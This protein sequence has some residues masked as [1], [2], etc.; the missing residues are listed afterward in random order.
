MQNE[1]NLHR[2]PLHV[3]LQ[4]KKDR[5]RLIIGIAI[6]AV[7]I[8]AAILTV[9][10]ILKPNTS[11]L[12]CAIEE[13]S[14]FGGTTSGKYVFHFNGDDD[15]LG[16][17]DF[18]ITIKPDAEKVPYETTIDDIYNAYQKRI[19]NGQLDRARVI[20]QVDYV[21]LEASNIPRSELNEY[22]SMAAI[23][24]GGPTGPRWPHQD[25][26]KKYIENKG[27]TCQ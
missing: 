27:M 4:P 24:V 12:S 16:S 3:D 22:V 14:Y 19:S 17:T 15:T 25:E 21:T 1:N 13:A 18:I 8:I 20:R 23:M 5:T 10:F 9:L 11:T 7:T 2:T 26:F 6:G